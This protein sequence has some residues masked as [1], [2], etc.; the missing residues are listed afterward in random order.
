[1]TDG[2]STPQDLHDFL[3]AWLPE[4]LVPATMTV[5]DGLP[6]RAS[7]YVIHHSGAEV[8]LPLSI[9]ENCGGP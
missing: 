2:R 4:H 6:L 9:R 7:G 3:C 1:V 5:L 8:D